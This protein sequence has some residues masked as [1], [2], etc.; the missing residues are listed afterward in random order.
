MKIE[1]LFAMHTATGTG[2]V[3][4][5]HG[6]TAYVTNGF[7]NNGVIGF[8]RPM[9]RD[10][11]Y[12]FS[13]LA[14]S[15]FGEATVQIPPFIAR[16]NG[17]SGLVVLEPITPMS[18]DQ[19]GYIAA[20]INTHI[21][22]RFSW[23]RVATVDR[24]KGFE[25]PNIDSPPVRYAVRSL[26]PARTE[27][28][29][30]SWRPRFKKVPL[31]A[32]FE[33]RPGDYHNA[34]VLPE[35]DIPLISCGDANNGIMAFVDVPNHCVFQSM[36]T[37]SFNG[38]NTLTTKYHPYRFATKDDVALC[39][40]RKPVRVSTLFFIQIMMARER[41]RYNYY[42]KCFM[43]K[44]KRQSVELPVRNGEIDEDTIYT[45]VSSTPYWAY[46]EKRFAAPVER[47]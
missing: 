41:W 9:P 37:I 2:F 38:M 29:K 27:Q 10:A 43:E 17:G 14:V 16:G 36:L 19:L 28:P 42:R 13:G 3:H 26:L 11:V 47:L 44:L 7:N 31:D 5:H 39:F 4:Y 8:V 22:W 40:P 12:S 45:I 30:P 15:A 24:L 35:G 21:R 20:Y 6:D 18:A 46:L 23:S 1:D 34:G 33:L 25:I 32:I